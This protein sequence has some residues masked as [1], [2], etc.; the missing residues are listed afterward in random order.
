MT[1]NRQPGDVGVILA[2]NRIHYFSE[3]YNKNRT[4]GSSGGLSFEHIIRET[5]SRLGNHDIP[6]P[7]CGPHQLTL[8][9]RYLPKLR[10][11][12]DEP[13]FARYNCV[14]CGKKGYVHDSGAP[15]PD[16]V[17][18]GR[19]KDEAAERERVSSAVTAQVGQ[20][21]FHGRT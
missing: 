9:K 10:V 7:F 6:C 5:C 1:C 4:I 14:R 12:R 3:H 2:M 11:Y 8:K 18:L 21:I 17:A 19:F 20:P 16:S 15:R 13:G